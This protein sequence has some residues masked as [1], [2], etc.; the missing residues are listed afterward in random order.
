MKRKQKRTNGAV[1]L[2]D[3]ALAAI[4]MQAIEIAARLPEPEPMGH[5]MMSSSY[6][7]PGK[8]AGKVIADAEKIMA[9]ITKR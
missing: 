2:D 9:F 3:N 1:W 8:D 7:R 4:R 6:T 5:G